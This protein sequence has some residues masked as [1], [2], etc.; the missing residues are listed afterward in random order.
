MNKK[1]KDVSMEKGLYVIKQGIE[2]PRE[3]GFLK[4]LIRSMKAGDLFEFPEEDIH[5][6]RQACYNEHRESTGFKFRTRRI[7]GTNP[8][9]YHCWKI[10]MRVKPKRVNAK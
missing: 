10:D 5:S 6:L 1:K 2:P 3:R 7:K 9:R 8:P 4:G